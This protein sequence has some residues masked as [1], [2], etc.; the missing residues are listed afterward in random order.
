MDKPQRKGRGWE[1]GRVRSEREESG[2]RRK[3]GEGGGAK[4]EKRRRKRR[5]TKLNLSSLLFISS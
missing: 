3:E 2:K 1:E 4:A 5:G